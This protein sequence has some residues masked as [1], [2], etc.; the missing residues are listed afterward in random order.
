MLAACGHTE[1]PTRPVGEDPVAL[2]PSGADVIIDVDVDQLRGWAA[3]KRFLGLLPPAARQRIDALG[4][5]PLDDVDAVWAAVYDLGRPTQRTLLL[6]KTEIELDRL[7]KDLGGEP[8]TIDHRGS[9]LL[10]GTDRSVARVTGK[11]LALGPRAEVRRALDL[12]RGDGESARGEKMLMAAWGRCPTAKVG[13]PAVLMAVAVREMVKEELRRQDL[14]GVDTEWFALS[15]A[16]G[17]GFDVG[18]VAA[19]RGPAEAKLMVQTGQRRKEDF[20]RTRAAK[21]LGLRTYLDPLLLVARDNE[22]H[23]VYR[24]PGT[25]VDRMLSRLESL[26]ASSVSPPATTKP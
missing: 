25:T 22:V 24:L 14:P 23:L 6:L 15:F 8:Q 26:M 3:T 17:D 5:D 7:G 21:L 1:T 9:K 20:S 11:I 10:E 4:F 2:L 18:A 19:A 12:A 13:R 16:V